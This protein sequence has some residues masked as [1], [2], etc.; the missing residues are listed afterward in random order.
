[1]EEEHGILYHIKNTISLIIWGGLFVLVLIFIFTYPR[2]DKNTTSNTLTPVSRPHMTA[3]K[4]V[5]I[6][7]KRMN[8]IDYTTGPDIWLTGLQEIS[9]I[10]GSAFEANVQDGLDNWE[11][12]YIPQKVVVNIDYEAVEVVDDLLLWFKGSHSQTADAHGQLW[13][14]VITDYSCQSTSY[15]C[16][17]IEV[18]IKAHPHVYV[19]VFQAFHGPDANRGWLYDHT[20]NEEEQEA[21]D[22][23]LA[24][25]TATPG[26]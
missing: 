21:W 24:E 6:G 15:F 2:Q 18:S 17:Q 25:R 11:T 8:R 22:K 14:A 3:Q 23:V 5:E 7:L 19:A 9:A 1:M 20:L 26:K 4:A 10:Y 16:S 13:K 12:I